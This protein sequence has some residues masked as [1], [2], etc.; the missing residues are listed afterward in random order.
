MVGNIKK[1]LEYLFYKTS[2]SIVLPWY[3]L[4]IGCNEFFESLP[5]GELLWLEESDRAGFFEKIFTGIQMNIFIQIWVWNMTF[6]VFR[7]CYRDC[8][9]VGKIEKMF[10]WSC[11]HKKQ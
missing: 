8:G 10:G 1:Q 9:P 4:R 2:V 7:I 3:F 6:L 5:Y 11:Y